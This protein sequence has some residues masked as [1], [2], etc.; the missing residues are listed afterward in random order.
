MVKHSHLKPTLILGLFSFLVLTGCTTAPP[1]IGEGLHGPVREVQ[2]EF[3]RR[4]KARFPIGSDETALRGELVREKF[5]ITR[6][7]E[8]PF[9]FSAVYQSGGIACVIHWRVEWSVF[10]GRIAAIDGNWGQ[11]CL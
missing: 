8:S 4:V 3:D 5:V 9:R 6:D 7:R 2:A 11:I 1:R 10:D